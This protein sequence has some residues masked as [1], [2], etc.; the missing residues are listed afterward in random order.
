MA[1]DSLDLPITLYCKMWLLP[2]LLTWF[3]PKLVDEHPHVWPSATTLLSRVYK[4]HIHKLLQYNLSCLISSSYDFTHDFT[5][6]VGLPHQPIPCHSRF[7]PR[8]MRHI[9]TC[10]KG[11]YS[12]SDGTCNKWWSW[13]VMEKQSTTNWW[14]R[15][16]TWWFNGDLIM[17]KQLSLMMMMMTMM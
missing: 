11:F 16:E 14:F 10:C 15:H 1:L 5:T 6:L 3:P 8:L 4:W 17:V 13:P 9:R 2:P 12:Q 7:K